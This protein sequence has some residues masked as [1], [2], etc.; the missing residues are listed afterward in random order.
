MMRE[1]SKV[2]PLVYFQIDP[3][4]GASLA[5]RGERRHVGISNSICEDG[6]N[7]LVQSA[8]KD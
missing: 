5:Q 4:G 6:L 2:L 8:V 7:T 1:R 3:D